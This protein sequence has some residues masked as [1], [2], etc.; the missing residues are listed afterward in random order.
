[1][2]RTVWREQKMKKLMWIISLISVAITA[3]A[4]TILPDRV[5][6]HSDIAG[7]IDRWGSKY[8]NFI[9]PVIILA[10]ALTMHLTIRYFEKQTEK[11][12]T[13]KERESARTNVKV[14]GIVGVVTTAMF[15]VMQCFI[16]YGAYTGAKENAAEMTVDIG[17]VSCILLG[18]LFIILGNFMTKTRTNSIIG[19]RI[20]WSM[21]ND[22]TWKKSN[23]FSAIV[24]I[25]AGILTIITAVLLKNSFAAMLLML[26]YL[27]AAVILSLIYAHKVYIE[28]LKA[29][30]EKE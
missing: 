10:L 2:G 1:M 4:V 22:T 5:P 23:R 12:K 24:L 13:E 21:Y 18:L 3:A 16:L 14:L 6:M 17:K 30:K 8:E 15:T 28:E 7:N 25:L 9:F 27:L 19:T 29:E 26:G 11:G 20:S